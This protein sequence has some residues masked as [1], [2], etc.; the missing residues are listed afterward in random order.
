[1]GFFTF[2]KFYK[3]YQIAQSIKLLTNVINVHSQEYVTNASMYEDTEK[4]KTKK[5]IVSRTLPGF[6]F[7]LK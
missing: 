3:W 4:S 6:Q 1:M 7:V 2:F 5:I